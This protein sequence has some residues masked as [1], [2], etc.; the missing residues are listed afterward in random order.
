MQGSI[1][2]LSIL[3]EK[4]EANVLGRTA[5]NVASLLAFGQA[6]E[7][8]IKTMC[9]QKHTTSLKQ[10]AYRT[11][12]NRRTGNIVGPVVLIDP[13]D[14]PY[15]QLTPTA[16]LWRY[17]DVRKFKELLCRSALYFSRPDKFTDPFEGRLSPAN[18]VAWAA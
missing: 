17:M 15:S 10:P 18:A 3:L 11:M 16:T 4:S 14:W 7:N 12:I 2:R 13:R 9:K 8:G 1:L 6:E 5:T